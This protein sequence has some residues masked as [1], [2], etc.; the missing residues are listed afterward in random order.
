VR[1]APLSLATCTTG[2]PPGEALAA[3]S[4]HH[5]AVHPE[6]VGK[7]LVASAWTADGIIEAIESA[8]GSA[9][10]EIGRFVLG[11]QWHPE[12]MQEEAPHRRLFL[13]L[14]EAA[15]RYRRRK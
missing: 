2:T 15:S 13:V 10:A 3:N 8:P 12:R 4:F 7:D 11:V 5:Q 9:W 6:R 1:F 14:V